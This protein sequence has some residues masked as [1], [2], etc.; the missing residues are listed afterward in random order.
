MFSHVMI[1]ANDLDKAKRFYDA[2]L[3]TLGVPSGVFNARGV[4]VYSH[5]GGR[6]LI[7]KPINGQAA[8][9]ANGGTL[10]F[11]ALSPAQVD[12]W[13]KAGL[14][15]GGTECEEPPGIREAPENRVVY[16]AL[17]RDPSGNKLCSVH[18]ISG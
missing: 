9:A 3:G 15:N 12:S 10:G 1:G 6:F 17:L 14:A 16:A 8:S 11:S 18:T 4:L 5:A 7:T 2:I 13:F